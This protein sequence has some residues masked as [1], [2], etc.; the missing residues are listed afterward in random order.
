MNLKDIYSS[1]ENHYNSRILSTSSFLLDAV[2]EILGT[3]E[4][5]LINNRL[6]GLSPVY[7][8]EKSKL[9]YTLTLD[10]L[11]KYDKEL[12]EILLDNTEEDKPLLI[13]SYHPMWTN[14]YAILSDLKN[15]Y[16][17]RPYNTSNDFRNLQ[18]T[19]YY[20]QPIFQGHISN[21]L[22]YLMNL[23]I[24]LG[25]KEENEIFTITTTNVTLDCETPDAKQLIYS[26][27]IYEISVLILNKFHEKGLYMLDNKF[28][29]NTY[30]NSTPDYFKTFYSYFKDIIILFLTDFKEF[31]YIVGK[32]NFERFTDS[33]LNE[34]YE[35]LYDIM[36]DMLYTKNINRSNIQIDYE[37]I[38]KGIENHKRK[39]KQT[40]EE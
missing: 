27:I 30:K 29:L 35:E 31:I 14:Q 12:I 17:L 1:I 33:L 37:S 5:E 4:K 10:N 11:N 32:N 15:K 19:L 40:G 38:L 39:L 28:M 13:G 34:N 22:T 7:T 16:S 36:N 18:F 20:R 26:T 8:V 3:E 6:K 24:S 9:E 2:I 21:D 23:L 25:I